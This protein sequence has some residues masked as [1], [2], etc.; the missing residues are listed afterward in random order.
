MVPRFLEEGVGA[1]QAVVTKEEVRRTIIAMH[2]FKA[3]SLD[4][5]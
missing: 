4:G 1:L 5:F 3:P 2:P